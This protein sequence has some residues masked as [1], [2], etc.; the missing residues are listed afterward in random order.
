MVI[1]KKI[2][3]ELQE[4][5]RNRVKNVDRLDEV[6]KF[7]NDNLLDVFSSPDFFVDGITERKLNDTID[8]IRDVVTQA[9]DKIER[10]LTEFATTWDAA[11]K[12][13]IKTEIKDIEDTITWKVTQIDMAWNISRDPLKPQK[14]RLWMIANSCKLFWFVD[15]TIIWNL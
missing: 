11:R 15:D 4:N 6:K 10:L 12:A 7:V 2:E 1:T 13:A 5:V 9:D 8:S 14:R 3:K